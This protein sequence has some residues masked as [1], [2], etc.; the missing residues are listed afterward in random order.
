[1]EWFPFGKWSVLT[2]TKIHS[3]KPS[4]DQAQI[5]W[6]FHHVRI[7]IIEHLYF[8]FGSGHRDLFKEA[9]NEAGESNCEWKCQDAGRQ[10]RW[11]STE[12]RAAAGNFQRLRSANFPAQG[13][14]IAFQQTRG[15]AAHTS[16]GPVKVTLANW[17]QDGDWSQNVLTAE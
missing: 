6:D 10:C 12:P 16:R 5:N 14:E 17:R 8:W 11:N 13:C 3:S 1:M 7:S 4:D 15:P 9:G 2:A